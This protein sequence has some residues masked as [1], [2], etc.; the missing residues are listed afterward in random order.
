MRACRLSSMALGLVLAA[1]LVVPSSADASVAQPTVVSSN[2]ADSTPQLV[3]TTAVPHP[4]VDA[5]AALGPV[6]FA[7]GNF[8]SIT[9]G[10]TTYPR[11]DLVSFDA[12]TGAVSSTFNPTLAGG[13]VW[14]IATD[15]ATN[16][17]YVGGEFTSVNGTTRAAL[18]K[19][20]ATTGVVDPL[21]RP[22]FHSGRITDLQLI[23]IGGVN[24]LVVAGNMGKRLF[25]LSPATG[26]DDGYFNSV[27]ATAIP[28]AW[29]VVAVYHFAVDP[30][31]THLVATGNFQTVDGAART[32]F[33]MLNLAPTG[34]TLSSWYY[35]GFAKRCSSTAPRRI[36]YLQGVD[37]SPSGD[38]FDVTATGQIPANASDIWY[39][40]LGANNKANTTVCDGVGR[41]TLADH[42]KPAWINYTGGD[43]V[44]SVSDTGAAVYV[45]GHF[46]WLDNPDGYTSFGIGDKTS[47]APAASR[48]G[49]GAIDPATGLTNSWKPGVTTRDGG[50]ALLATPTGLWV[51]DDST[52]FGTERHYGIAF[53]P[54]S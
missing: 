4:H 48:K 38:A 41:F 25:S 27:I 50:K 47:G 9:Q 18:V 32:R 42:T 33:F 44:W 36:A 34:A 6:M 2:A 15:P 30:S 49:I 39:K 37:W 43:S 5:V 40:R 53:A 16:S 35:P 45:Q 29:G 26:A 10:G 46:K 24:R 19:L 13:Q 23:S 1:L 31:R 20:N 52:R 14:A 8:D 51:G 22:P 11:I 3:A 21:F 28:G 54:L 17:V 7:G 12:S